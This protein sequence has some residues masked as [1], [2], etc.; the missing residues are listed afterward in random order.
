M[1]GLI[2]AA[3]AP[4]APAADSAARPGPT[5][6]SSANLALH[7][8]S[9]QPAPR[10]TVQHFLASVKSV[11]A[12]NAYELRPPP[13][14][15]LDHVK[16]PP[17]AVEARRKRRLQDLEDRG[18]SWIRNDGDAAAAPRRTAAGGR[19]GSEQALVMLQPDT[20]LH[21]SRAGTANKPPA[22]KKSLVASMMRKKTKP[23]TAAA[24]KAAPPLLESNGRNSHASDESSILVPRNGARAANAPPAEN[25]GKKKEGR[26]KAAG[27]ENW[28]EGARNSS[29]RKRKDTGESDAA[30]EDELEARLKARR[31]RRRQNALIR[32]DRSL[33]AAAV[34]A[35]AAAKVKKAAKKRKA[36]SEVGTD[37][38]S[39]EDGDEIALEAAERKR[40]GKGTKDDRSRKRVGGL[41]RPGNVG[42]GRLTLGIFSKGKA[43][44]RAK[45]GAQPLA[46]DE[47]AFLSGTRQARAPSPLSASSASS[48]SSSASSDKEARHAVNETTSGNKGKSGVKTY[49]SRP[50]KRRSGS[51]PRRNRFVAV[52][53]EADSEASP[54][55]A[56]G[57]SLADRNSDGGVEE[58]GQVKRIAPNQPAT[59]PHK[60]KRSQASP[61]FWLDIPPWPRSASV[62]RRGAPAGQGTS[63]SLRRTIAEDDGISTPA[64]V[65]SA[66]SLARRKA[67]RAEA[68]RKTVVSPSE[69]QAAGD[70]GGVYVGDTTDGVALSEREPTPRPVDQTT[71]GAID[72]IGATSGFHDDTEELDTS[73]AFELLLAEVA[74]A[75]E[76]SVAAASGVDTEPPAL[77]SFRG[78]TVD[79]QERLPETS[80]QD[81]LAE[82]DLDAFLQDSQGFDDGGFAGCS[83][84]AAM[85][86]AEPALP[87]SAIK[88]G[89]FLDQTDFSLVEPVTAFDGGDFELDP[90]LVANNGTDTSPPERF[91]TP[92]SF[93]QS[94]SQAEEGFGHLGGDRSASDEYQLGLTDEK[95][96]RMAMRQ[97]WPKTLL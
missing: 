94:F 31:D 82:V 17:R 65:L 7:T 38:G 76:G 25:K 27:K 95:A 78:A 14:G 51:A 60:K 84:A 52:E 35:S 64:S 13:E 86:E 77:R 3:L 32:K 33:P 70:A 18:E 57:F 47:Q 61:S 69:E 9:N 26:K 39:D 8:S 40:K 59:K 74:S 55:T 11:H 79:P 44:T 42:A 6:L 2:A 29:S 71:T 90:T 89:P 67:E 54:D 46:F 68:A 81:S 56:I 12:A 16:T 92:T 5:P 48:S 58:L 37:A 88:E 20:G 19:G 96:F 75:A 66:A 63:P 4:T 43:S 24:T 23:T 45:I 62:A 72:P 80:M 87:I 15:E 49:G 50:S 93:A 28:P 21:A 34:G 85:M 97:Q 1:Q 10:R 91:A 30:E 36:G 41:D 22:P 83:S 73:G 53:A